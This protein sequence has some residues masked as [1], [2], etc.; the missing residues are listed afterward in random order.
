[1]KNYLKA[2]I[3]AEVEKDAGTIPLTPEDKQQIIRSTKWFLV[4]CF[5]FLGAGVWFLC[6]KD[7]LF[8]M[9]LMGIAC[10]AQ[11]GRIQGLYT[12]KLAEGLAEL[13]KGGI[14]NA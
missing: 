4:M 12:K 5:V 10:V 1:M 6:T 13:R 14:G 11:S 7:H 2:K 3:E 9:T 8:V